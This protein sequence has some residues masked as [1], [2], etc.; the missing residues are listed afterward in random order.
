MHSETSSISCGVDTIYGF[1]HEEPGADMETLMC[2]VSAAMW[3]T[4]R[5]QSMS[6][7]RLAAAVY[8]FSDIKGD[9]GDRFGQWLKELF[10]NDVQ[11]IEAKN[12]NSG[13]RI[14]TYMWRPGK[15][16][17]KIPGWTT[18]RKLGMELA[19]ERSYW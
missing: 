2:A 1:E 9:N 12:P 15:G 5:E 10:P 8:L 6:R 19:A 4:S 7:S 16:L 11:A 13:N 17:T 18:G 3:A 14:V